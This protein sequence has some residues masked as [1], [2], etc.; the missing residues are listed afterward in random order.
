VLR[1]PLLHFL[2]LGA[3]LFAIRTAASRVPEVPVVE[4]RR[5]DIEGQI[6]AYRQQLGRPL[7]VSESAAIERQVVENAIWL[8]QARTL[9]LQEVDP[10]VQQRLL[11]NMRFLE[12]DSGGSDEVLLARAL[13][14]GMDR[15]DPV[16]ERRLVDRVQAIVRAGVR[17][18]PPDEAELARH[19]RETAERWR[20]PPLLDLTHVYLSRDR[21]GEA[22]RADAE[23]LVARLRAEATGPDEAV[24][25]GDPFLS[26]H[27]LRGATPTRVVSRLGPEFEA[28]VREAPV[29]TWIGPIESAFGLHAVWIHERTPSRLPP[30]AEIR[31]RVL[32]DWIEEASREALR[33]HVARRREQVELRIVEDAG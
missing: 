13:E 16:V 31:E 15:S 3:L 9:G 11:L 8:Q 6:E 24:A 20:E 4:V 19:Y 1:S 26:G 7:S 32:E 2:A 23:A 28:G 10:V 17:A 18:R 33:E 14:L 21:R 25:L 27:R 29:A 22:T 5:S 30:L 12:G